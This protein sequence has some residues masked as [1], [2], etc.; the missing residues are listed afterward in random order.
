M[1]IL[2]TPTVPKQYPILPVS[3]K[4]WDAI[5]QVEEDMPAGTSF[6]V[7]RHYDVVSSQVILCDYITVKEAPTHWSRLVAVYFQEERTPY[8]PTYDGNSRHRAPRRLMN[9][10]VQSTAGRIFLQQ[11]Q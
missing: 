9:P 8:P 6:L 2:R 7:R 4:W 1:R 11:D 10:L 5:E 3:D